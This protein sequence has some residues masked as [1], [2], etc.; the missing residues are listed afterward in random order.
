[1]GKGQVTGPWQKLLALWPL[2]RVDLYFLFLRLLTILGGLLWLLFVPEDPLHRTVLSWLFVGYV[3]YSMTLYTGILSW[4]R[5]VKRLYLTAMVIDL[6]FIFALILFVGRLRGSFFI[7][8]YLLVAIHAFYFGLPVGL[9]AALASSGLYG[10]LYLSLHGPAIIPV[11]DFLLRLSF[12][13]LIAVSLGLLAGR[14]R[15]DRE[16]IQ[17]LNRQLHHRNL[18]LEQVYHYLS[19]G[20]LIGRI[21]HN[22][23]NP[24]GIVML[25]AALLVQEAKEL[26]LPDE[27]IKGL[28]VI[29]MHVHRIT[30]VIRLLLPFSGRGDF[31]LRPLDLNDIVQEALLLL[32]DEFRERKVVVR[33]DLDGNHPI[34]GDDQSLREVLLNLLSNALDALPNGGTIEVLT[35]EEEGMVKCVIADNGVGIPAEDLERIFDPFFTTKGNNGIGLGLSI[36]L[37]IMKRHNGLISVQSEP[38]K[39]T[40]F[41]LSFPRYSE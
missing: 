17:G 32:E 2:E 13:F 4:P 22:V 30:W 41:T 26:K 39:G 12:L 10:V 40:A 14:E 15:R 20:K 29:L 3:V 1:M 34:L 6:G 37:G 25:K 27:F 18:I 9:I 19:I 11:Q 24:A 16:K 35:R 21:A 36:T 8:F 38:G 5:W 23:N 7:A 31:R 33:T 28:E